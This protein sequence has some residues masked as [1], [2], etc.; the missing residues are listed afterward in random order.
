MIPQSNHYGLKNARVP[1]A[2]MEESE[3][4]VQTR[5][6]LCSVDIEIVEG[7]IAR[8]QSTSNNPTDFP[9]ID[10][11]QGIVLPCFVDLHTH[12][13]KAHIWERSRN[14]DCTFE[15][16]IASCQKDAKKYWN[17][18]DLYRR[19]EFVLKCS[20][21]HGTQALR[22][23][24][25]ILD[26]PESESLAV[27]QQLQT[28]WRDRITLQVVSLVTLDYFQ[29]PQ[30]VLLA[31][32]IAEMGGILGGVAYLNPELDAQLDA[33]FSLAKERNLDLDFHV[34]ENGNPDSNCLEKVSRTA[35]RH[36]FKG[37]ILCGH[38]CSLTVQSPKQI[39]AT[40]NLVKAAG[41]GIVSLPMCNQFLQDRTPNQT[42][43]WRGIPPIHEIKQKGIPVAFANDNC[44]D[45]FFGFG[46][47]DVLEVFNQ[48]VRIAQLDCPYGDW[49]DSV[50][51]TPAD[52]MG[53]PNVGR[54]GVGLPA[55]L[56]LFKARYF[57]ELLAR[58]QRDRAVLRNGKPIDT[59]LPPY[60][61][62][63]DLMA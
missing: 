6:G 40:L 62:L 31:D 21:A 59:T 24:L 50:T 63:D 56:I 17:P 20:Y 9:T 33:V 5:D 51:R 1:I 32:K 34:D 42:P 11:Q 52:L 27:F 29:S 15:R 4:V 22:T 30:G 3:D 7:A 19:M 13:D 37:K 16:A 35:L 47:G 39:T 58:S 18:E 25:D 43:F 2:A 44:R 45:P 54:I 26:A 8:I 46:D 61:E 57:S 38:C 14:P 36:Q 49:I 55:N 41:I 28:E 23:H 12:L 60:A 10:L 53:L 48:A